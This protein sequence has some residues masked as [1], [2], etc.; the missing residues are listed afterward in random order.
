MEKLSS[1]THDSV[2][3]IPG[4]DA[5]KTHN[6]RKDKPRPTEVPSGVKKTGS[7]FLLEISSCHKSLVIK[8]QCPAF[9]R[10]IQ[11]IADKLFE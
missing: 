11:D 2:L 10:C 8:F 9:S 4:F 7:Y 3:Y 5:D 6:R 1:E